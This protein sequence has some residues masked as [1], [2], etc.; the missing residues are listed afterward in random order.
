[1]LAALSLSPVILMALPPQSEEDLQ[2]GA[3]RVVVG[4]VTAVF[5]REVPVAQ[6]TDTESVATVV[7]EKGAGERLLYVH[8]RQAGKRPPGWTG[9][10]GQHAPLRADRKKV[11]LYLVTGPDGA[12]RLLEPNGWAPAD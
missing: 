3:Q 2:R 6:G 5:S 9:P 11:R 8:F 1:M 10:G 4:E 12:W 7:P